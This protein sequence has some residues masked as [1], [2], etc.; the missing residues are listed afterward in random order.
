MPTKREERDSNPRAL[1]DKRFSRPPRYDRFAISSMLPQG[2]VLTSALGDALPCPGMSGGYRPWRYFPNIRISMPFWSSFYP[3]RN[4]R[5]PSGIGRAG[6][7][8]LLY[9][10]HCTKVISMLIFLGN[11][12]FNGWF[13]VN[14][15]AAHPAYW[16]EPSTSR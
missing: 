8:R 14:H 16:P 15:L 6:F 10:G 1:S 3:R 9:L 11:C 2:C 7:F 12:F 4:R 5:L 13:K